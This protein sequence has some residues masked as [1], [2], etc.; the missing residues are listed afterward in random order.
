MLIQQDLEKAKRPKNI[1][2]KYVGTERIKAE[3]I[4]N[5]F[6]KAFS[7]VTTEHKLD[8]AMQPYIESY[9]FETGKDMKLTVK[10][11]LK[12]EV[13]LAKYKENKVDFEEFKSEKDALDK[14]T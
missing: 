10:A 13:K 11:E 5:L 7:D 3:A 4:E 8:L 14:G 1:V 12:P 9:D 2:E 6:P